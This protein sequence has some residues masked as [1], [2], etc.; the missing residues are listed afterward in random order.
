LYG[1]PARDRLVAAEVAGVLLAPSGRVS[2]VEPRGRRIDN[3]ASP[4]QHAVTRAASANRWS[5]QLRADA[6]LLVPA[7]VVGLFWAYL[8]GGGGAVWLATTVITATF[9]LW[10]AALR[11]SDPS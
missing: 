9:G 8:A 7:P 1:D 2:T 11:G 3:P 10:W 4:D 5:R 6:A